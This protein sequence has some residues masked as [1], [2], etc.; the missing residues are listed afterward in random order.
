MDRAVRWIDARVLELYSA[1]KAR[2]K[3]ATDEDWL[4]VVTTDHGRQS[5]DGK[6]H[7]GQSE[8]E[9]TIWIASNTPRMV[10]SGE[11]NAAIVDIYPTIAEHMHF[12]VPDEVAAQLEGQS[13]LSK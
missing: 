6:S 7:G 12:E 13:L 8:R 10:S 9:R 2:E 4:V 5:S 11:R 3:L 1:V